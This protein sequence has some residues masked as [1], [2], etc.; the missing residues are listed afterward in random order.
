MKVITANGKKS[1][2]MSKREWFELGKKAGWISKKA[3]DDDY[4][5]EDIDR[6]LM[7][8]GIDPRQMEQQVAEE[9]AALEALPESEKAELAKQLDYVDPDI[10]ADAVE[11]AQAAQRERNRRM[12]EKRQKQLQRDVYSKEPIA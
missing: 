6:M 3:Y 8:E 10:A 11:K 12:E 5:E 1:L 7:E 2:R 9:E 4:T